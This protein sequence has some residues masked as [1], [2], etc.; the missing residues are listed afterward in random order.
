[1]VFRRGVA[2]GVTAVFLSGCA[3]ERSG[4]D[5]A[6]VM[7]KLGPPRPGQ[8]RIVVLQEKASGLTA[9]V[10]D[11][12]LDGGPMGILKTGTYIY[13]D[14][15]A[16]RHQLLATETLFPGESKRDIKTESG[17]TYFFLAKTSERHNTVTGA[18]IVGGLAGMVAASVVTS[19]NDSTGPV[20][21]V[22][23]DEAAARTMLAELQLA[24]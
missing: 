22:S 12:K 8:S 13:A 2:I 7:Q 5:Y 14:R 16:G 11:V 1:M 17:R 4:F 3:S 18:T 24:E 21:F 15:P 19:G 6:G 9:T 10:S 23:L 20:D